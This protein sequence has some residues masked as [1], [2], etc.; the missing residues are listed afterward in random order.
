MLR[1]WQD[2]FNEAGFA[3]TGFVAN[4]ACKAAPRLRMVRVA[5]NSTGT[6]LETEMK[7]CRGL[8]AAG[9]RHKGTTRGNSFSLH[10]LQA[11][12]WCNTSREALSVLQC[13][14]PKHGCYVALDVAQKRLYEWPPWYKPRALQSHPPLKVAGL[15]CGCPV[16]PPSWRRSRQKCWRRWHT[17]WPQV[18]VLSPLPSF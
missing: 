1:S 10:F 18:E 12:G 7:K 13:K 3:L 4:C 5:Q 9:K 16:Q 8:E 11:P 17:S 6:K 2:S 15:A 14:P